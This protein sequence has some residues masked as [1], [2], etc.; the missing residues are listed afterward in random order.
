MSNEQEEEKYEEVDDQK[1]DFDP[2][3]YIKGLVNVCKH[4]FNLSDK[5][6]KKIRKG[7]QNMVYTL[8][9]NFEKGIDGTTFADYED[10]VLKIF[11]KNRKDILKDDEC[12][13][14]NNDI[15]F[16]LPNDKAKS[17]KD[18]KVIYLSTAYKKAAEMWD[19]HRNDQVGS[20][21]KFSEFVLLPNRFFRY[22]YL[23]FLEFAE[24]GDELDI[25]SDHLDKVETQLGITDRTYM[26]NFGL[27]GL[28]GG[29]MQETLKNIL[30]VV[31]KAAKSNGMEIEG[32]DENINM[33]SL[34][35]SLLKIF[36]DGNIMGELSKEL[37]SCDG[38]KNE[39]MK[40][41]YKKVANPELREAIKKATGIDLDQE[42]LEKIMASSE[43]SEK[44][45]S[46]IGEIF[47]K[48]N[49][50]KENK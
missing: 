14:L 1:A 39:I 35:E 44:V 9:L 38:N 8:L 28:F 49:F 50:F 19:R 7:R 22:I 23:L 26:E 33:D 43:V 18:Q 45:E 41:L 36:T 15:K 30:K 42:N 2:I 13:L 20:D 12:W 47:P 21:G 37:S 29:N 46:V 32:L 4:I 10:Q 31:M 40:V 16:S 6:Q 17:K 11:L 48:M 27:G 24:E 5:D 3:N 25:I 34:I